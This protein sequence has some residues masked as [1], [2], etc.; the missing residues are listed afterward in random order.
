MYE[1]VLILH[2]LGIAVGVGTSIFMAGLG[3][4]TQKLSADAATNLM[5][6]VGPTASLLGAAGYL[7]LVVTGVL[8]LWWSDWV[9]AEGG[10]AWFWIK[11]GL[12]VVLG[13]LLAMIHR[14]SAAVR[15]SETPEA[16]MAK[17]ETLGKAALAASIGIVIAAVLAF[18]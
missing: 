11:I 15:S 12:V 3:I 1:A 9:L 13:G 16:G 2:M 18:G 14:F 4:R 6:Q 5:M 17:L 8:M 10:G 7:I